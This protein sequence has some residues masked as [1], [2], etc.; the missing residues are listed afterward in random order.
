MKPSTLLLLLLTLFFLTAC[1]KDQNKGRVTFYTNAQYVLNCGPFDVEI[2]IDNSLIGVIKESYLPLDSTPECYSL[3]N[4]R[5]L[6]L[7]EP[8]GDYEFTARLTCS[9]TLKYLGNFRVKKDSCS[10]VYIDLTYGK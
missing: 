1:E 3:S 4:E 2:Y 6:S 9:E 8:E 10:L 7:E 5:L